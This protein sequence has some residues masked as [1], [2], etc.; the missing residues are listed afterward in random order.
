MYVN[1]YDVE[2]S[3]WCCGSTYWNLAWDWASENTSWGV[4]IYGMIKSWQNV[5]V[6][7]GGG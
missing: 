6:W 4:D 1:S 7:G 2:R 5:C 3:L